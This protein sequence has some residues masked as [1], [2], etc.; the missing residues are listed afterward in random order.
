[1]RG[2][3]AALAL[4]LAVP[5]AHAGPA[6]APL[7][8]GQLRM[9]EIALE[10]AEAA[11][12]IG[13]YDIADKLAWQAGLDARLAWSMTDSQFVRRDAA[14][15]HAQSLALRAQLPRASGLTAQARGLLGGAKHPEE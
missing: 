15:L 9:A 14:E 10:H 4:L 8:P 12:A 7:A 2:R 1:M 11:L 13:E 5:A 6:T 3:L